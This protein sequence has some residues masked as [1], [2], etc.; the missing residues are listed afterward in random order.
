MNESKKGASLYLIGAILFA[1]LAVRMALL[2][3]SAEGYR[4]MFFPRWEALLDPMVWIWAMG[5]A[6]FSL[7]VAGNVSVIYGS[8]LGKDVEI[9]SSARNVAVFDTLA[10]LVAMFVIIPAMATSGGELS[11]AGPGLMFV[12]LP[13]VFNGMGSFGRF[14]GIFFF[15]A[16]LFAG[17]TSIINLYETPVAFWMP[18]TWQGH[19]FH[20]ATWQSSFGG[21]RYQTH[22]SHGCV[23]MPYSKAEQLFGMISAGTPVIVH[24]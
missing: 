22:G 8:Y 18:F 9:S 4:F 15:V 10:A 1:V 21:S 6:F 13:G 14:V 11:T 5:Q 16:V 24:N 19:G 12:A 23:N 17:T 7:S 20:D 3:G 2:P